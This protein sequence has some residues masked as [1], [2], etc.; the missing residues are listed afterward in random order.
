MDLS[1]FEAQMRINFFGVLHTVHAAYP[2]MVARDRGHLVLVG[3]ALS[4]FGG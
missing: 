2:A 1:A 3:S 4:T